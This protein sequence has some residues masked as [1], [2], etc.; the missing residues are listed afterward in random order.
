MACYFLVLSALNW[1]SACLIFLPAWLD[2]LWPSP[3]SRF[4]FL[5]TARY[6]AVIWSK[7]AGLEF[8]REGWSMFGQPGASQGWPWC[9]CPLA[10]RPLGLGYHFLPFCDFGASFLVLGR[11]A[12]QGQ[13]CSWTSRAVLGSLP[14]V[15]SFLGIFLGWTSTDP[16]KVRDGM[17]QDQEASWTW[18]SRLVFSSSSTPL[19]KIQVQI[20]LRHFFPPGVMTAN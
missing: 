9:D 8:S 5:V 16:S 13:G 18:A 20:Y 3:V 15:L 19:K 4:S 12:L 14:Q 11:L 2:N 6:G 1:S 17:G 10:C 7:W